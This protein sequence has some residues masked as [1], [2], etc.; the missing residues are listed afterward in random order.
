MLLYVVIF[1][2]LRPRS[3][4]TDII[5][6]TIRLLIWLMDHRVH[7]IDCRLRSR[8]DVVS[9]S[10]YSSAY[11]ITT[12]LLFQVRVNKSWLTECPEARYL[13]KANQRAFASS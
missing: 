7:S 8:L 13:Q 11:R 4:R 9:S 5:H 10:H 6:Y 12:K 2:D 1:F 3:G